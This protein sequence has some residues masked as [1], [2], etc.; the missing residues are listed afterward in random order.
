MVAA[1]ELGVA[2]RI[3]CIPTVVT[4][5]TTS[6]DYARINPT[7]QLP[8]LVLDDGTTI[9]DSLVICEYL[10]AQ[11]GAH[12]LL[13]LQGSER[14]GVLKRHELGDG[15]MDRAVRWLG[16]IF[17]PPGL[18]SDDVVDAC[19]SAIETTLDALERD[20]AT[21]P[22]ARFDL[23]DIATATA[24]AYLDFRFAVID[25]RASRPSLAAAYEGWAARPAMQKTE[26]AKLS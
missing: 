4:A 19:R 1:H 2:D 7:G 6:A 10:D 9:L 17:R 13:P 21:W 22:K 16:E 8:A 5:E 20:A 18:K 14:F 24:L 26:F 15:L 3:A 11:Y 25:W 23:G 12:R